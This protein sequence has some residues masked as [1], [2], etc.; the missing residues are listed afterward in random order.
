MSSCLTLANENGPAEIICLS[1]SGLTLFCPSLKAALPLFSLPPAGVA[2]AYLVSR[3]E[4]ASPVCEGH[5]MNGEPQVVVAVFKEKDLRF[6]NEASA[7]LP[8]HLHHLLHT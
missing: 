5:V 6:V 2:T 7:Q 3:E 1:D 4:L 8:L